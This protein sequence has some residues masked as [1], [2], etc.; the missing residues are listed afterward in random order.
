MIEK[1]ERT[2]ER[3][4]RRVFRVASSSCLLDCL[5]FCFRAFAQSL[6]G[7]CVCEPVSISFVC[8]CT[9]TFLFLLF[10]V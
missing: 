7:L 1:K 3:N 5:L 9:G 10:F 6:V 8:R 2:E 4:V